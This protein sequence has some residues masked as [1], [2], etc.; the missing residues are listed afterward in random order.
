MIL[1]NT[2]MGVCAGLALI[3]VPLLA[4]KLYRRQ[5]IAPEGWAI[6][7]GILGLILTFLS[8]LMAVTWPLTVNPPINIVFSEPN[9]VFGVLLLAA[10]FFLW[11]QRE[12]IAVMGSGDKKLADAAEANLDRVLMPVSWLVFTLGLILAACTAAIFRF[13]L[14]GGAPEAEPITGRLHDM[15]WIENTFFGILYGLSALGALLAPFALRNRRSFAWSIMGRVWIVAG[16]MFLLFSVMN[17]YTHVGLLTN[18]Q[19]G[20]DYKF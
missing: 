10:S 2:L 17:Y 13:M 1:Y 14:V 3:L 11:K 18:I 6:T 12:V 20:T 9:L 15:P 16:V 8:G 7:F 4:R 19:K 5:K